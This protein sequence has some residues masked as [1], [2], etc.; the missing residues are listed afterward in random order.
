MIK[1]NWVA[2]G[3]GV[4]LLWAM[5]ATALPAQTFTTLV[6]LNESLGSAWPDGGLVQGTDGNLYGVAFGNATGEYGTIIKVTPAG[7]FTTIIN[8]ENSQAAG[9]FG[10]LVL[11]TD[12]DFYGA[13]DEGTTD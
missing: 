3:C 11:G 7:E 9:P 12:G 10:V 8:L 13:T 5:A 6:N 1:L 4:I 2:K